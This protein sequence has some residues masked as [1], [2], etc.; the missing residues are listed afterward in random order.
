MVI[1]GPGTGKT[2]VLALRIANILFKTDA[3]PDNI[4]A[5]TFTDV[6]AKNMR[7]RLLKI[8]GKEAYY[9]QIHTFHSYCSQ[10]MTNY[11]EYFPLKN[12]SEALEDLERY[13]IFENLIDQ[14]KPKHLRPLNDHYHY[15]KDIIKAISDLKREGISLLEFEEII[16]AEKKRLVNLQQE[17]KSKTKIKQASKEL[18]KQRAIINLS[19]YQQELVESNRYD[20]DDMINFV[21]EHLK[22]IRIII[23]T[24][25]TTSTFFG[26]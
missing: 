16:E 4:L 8:I 26:R 5:L 3:K 24:T 9:L 23:R 19:T 22:N 11:P 17:S 18:A 21:I 15:L 20:F 2:Q 7:E 10:V 6:A 14:L 1:A 13:Q 25:R 12:N